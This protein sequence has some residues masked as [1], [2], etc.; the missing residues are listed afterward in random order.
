MFVRWYVE[1]CAREPT[2]LYLKW[3]NEWDGLVPEVLV[4]APP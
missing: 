1:D 3:L 2:L 4:R